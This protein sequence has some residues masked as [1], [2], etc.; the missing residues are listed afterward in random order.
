MRRSSGLV[1]NHLRQQAGNLNEK[2]RSL[3]QP[4]PYRVRLI[5]FWAKPLVAIRLA[6]STTLKHVREL[7]FSQAFGRV[8]HPGLLITIHGPS[9]TSFVLPCRAQGCFL[10]VTQ[11]MTSFMQQHGRAF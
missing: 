1:R 3:A 2:T 11:E 5:G 8:P 6:V 7:S 9:E 4:V 10:A